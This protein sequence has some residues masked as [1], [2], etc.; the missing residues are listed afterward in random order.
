[1]IVN[2][3][4]EEDKNAT[5]YGK[6]YMKFDLIKSIRNILTKIIVF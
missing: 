3:E 4:V 2:S 1:M 6:I 5:G